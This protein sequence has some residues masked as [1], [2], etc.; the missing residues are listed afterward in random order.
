MPSGN[1]D[2]NKQGREQVYYVEYRKQETFDKQFLKIGQLLQRL[3]WQH[4][5]ALGG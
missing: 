4:V 3:D 5:H 2:G 1:F